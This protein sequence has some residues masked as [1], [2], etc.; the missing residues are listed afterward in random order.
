MF[1]SS[2]L[3][4]PHQTIQA[5]GSDVIPDFA[6]EAVIVFNL[7]WL[8]QEIMK[9]NKNCLARERFRLAFDVQS[10]RW[11]E[12]FALGVDDLCY[13][14]L[15]VSFDPEVHARRLRIHPRV[16]PTRA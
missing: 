14:S 16:A 7:C 2:R 9:D 13:M 3:H 8:H 5:E 6:R 10:F 4:L 1:E 12:Y 15:I 11:I